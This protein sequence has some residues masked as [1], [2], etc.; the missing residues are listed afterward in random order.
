[1]NVGIKGF[2]AYAP[3]KVVDNAYFE[4]FLET[5]DEWISKMTGIKE[6]R[7]ASEDQD[8][9]DLA[10]EASKKAIEDAGITPADID[11][12]IVATATGDMPFPSVA[13]ILQEKLGTRKVPTM[14]QLA[15]CS[16]FMYSMITA[17]QYVQSGDYKNI[18]VVGAD[19]L[20]KIT[21]LTDR[22]TA[23][24]FGDGAGAVV[25]GEVSEG[26]G[27][28]SYEMGSDGNGGKYLYLNKD[29]GKLVMNG[30]EVFK[31]AV[32]IM[33]EASTRVVDKAG[34]Q[35]DDIDMFI[36]HQANIRI[37]ESARERLG[38]EREKMSVSV[39]RFGNTSAAS[40]PLSISQELENGRIK[41]DDTLVL[42]GFGG[43]LTWGAMVIKWGK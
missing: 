26:R 40:I 8:T 6:R 30:R 37:M 41:D 38:I 36:P 18:L 21:D 14:D 19:K 22:S 15:A 35:S 34:L 31:F 24:L 29:A 3:E 9:S 11:M 28:I 17:K 7:W 42:V 25:I 2:G 32:R 39:N 33:G 5:S 10:F 20:S 13:N 4:S 1:M 12:I 23:V 16:G 43:G 27:I